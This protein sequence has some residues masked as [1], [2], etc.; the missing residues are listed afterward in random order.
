MGF[1]VIQSSSIYLWAFNNHILL[2]EFIPDKF[3]L[4]SETKTYNVNET[5]LV[6]YSSSAVLDASCSVILRSTMNTEGTEGATTEGQK[7]LPTKGPLSIHQKALFVFWVSVML[8]MVFKKLLL[9]LKVSPLR[10]AFP[11]TASGKVVWLVLCKS[12]SKSFSGTV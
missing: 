8:L 6:A 5:L 3:T 1:S 7:W 11:H 10:S 12:L 9:L 4:V 2:Y